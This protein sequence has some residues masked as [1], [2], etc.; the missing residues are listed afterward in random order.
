MKT[1]QARVAR[2]VKEDPSVE[3]CDVCNVETVLLESFPMK[4]YL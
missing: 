2:K 3:E 4:K 1:I